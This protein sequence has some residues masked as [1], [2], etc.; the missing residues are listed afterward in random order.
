MTRLSTIA[1]TI[2]ILLAGTAAAPA[3]AQDVA[4][5]VDPIEDQ[6][7]RE[8]AG[9]RFE[10][11][12]KTYR[13]AFGTAV[14]QAAAGTARERNLA[15]AEVLLEKIDGLTERVSEQRSTEEFLSG[16]D[17]ERL[18]PVL[19]G[20]VDWRRARYR[21]AAGDLEGAAELLGGLGIVSDWWVIGPF[22][23]ERGR[24]YKTAAEPETKIDL[25]G[26][27]KGKEREVGWRKAPGATRNGYVNLDAML[28]P[29]DQAFA[30]AVAFVKS[31]S[32]QDA[33]IRLGSDEAVK[34]W[35]NGTQV[36]DRDLRRRIAFDQ[37]VVGVRARE[38]WNVL[39][40][41]VHDQTGSWGFRVRLTA[42]D[43]AALGGVSFATTREEADAA[44]AA[45]AEAKDVEGAVAGGARQFYDGLDEGARSAREMFHL[46]LLHHRRGFDAIAD[47]K[48]AKHLEDAA[49]AEPENSI[50]RYHYAQAA[51]PPVE[52]SVEKE[53]NRQRQA[54]EQVLAMDPSYAVA[55]RALAGYYTGSLTNLEKAEQLLRKALELNPDFH[56][57]RLDLA[58]VLRRRGLN[59]AAELERKKVV[60][61][62]R[63][64]GRERTARMKADELQRNGYAKE[65]AAAWEA[66]L[67]VDARSQDARRRIADLSV[68]VLARDEA[69]ALL[70]KMHSYDPYDTNSLRR[71]AELFEGAGEFD[72][73]E[74]ELRRALAVVPE[75]HGLLQALGRVQLKAGRK[76]EA[77]DTYR[78][79]LVINPKLQ[80][81]ERYVEYLDPAA[82]PYEDAYRI[83][84]EPL[85]QAAADY[86]N[87]ENDGY[88]VLLDQSVMKV[89]PDGTSSTY[90]HIAVKILTNDGVQQWRRHSVNTWGWAFKWKS[91]RVVKADG[92]EVQ[93]KTRK[94]RFQAVAQFPPLTPGDV[95]EFEYRQDQRQQSFFGDYFGTDFYFADRVPMSLSTLTLITPASREFYTHSRHIDIEPT[96][97]MSEDGQERVFVWTRKDCP[98]VRFERGMPAA[99]EIYPMVQISTF[100]DWNAFATWFSSLIRDQ[101]IASDPIKEKV[102]ELVEGKETRYEKVR[103]LYD[104]VTGEITYQAWP[105]NVHAYKPYTTT[106]IFDKREGDCKDKAILFNTMLK[107]IGV[108]AYPVL[109]MAEGSRSAEDFTLPV[110]HHFNHCISYVPDADGN[111]KALFLDGTAQYHSAGG[112]PPA[113]DRGA[114]VL[115]VKPDGGVIETIP[116]GTP[117]DMGIDQKWTVTVSED[118]KAVIEGEM[119]FRGDVATAFR[120]IFSV[121]GQRKL[122]LQS[123]L[124]QTFGKVRIQETDFDD[125]K[126]LAQPRTS[127]RMKVEVSNFAKEDGDYQT[128]PASFVEFVS[129]QFQ[130]LIARTER[131][132]DLLLSP[133]ISERTEVTYT[134]PESW[135]VEVAP[136]NATIEVDA[137]AFILDASHEGNTL[138]LKRTFEVRQPRVRTDDYPTFRDAV[139]RAASVGKQTWKLKKTAEAE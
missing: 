83:E 121:E 35:W 17:A 13:K 51:A 62:P 73:A 25:A 123:I 99:R 95:V 139:S 42:A 36:L 84:V 43:G 130:S 77:L 75:S 59:A 105:L 71:R 1:L 57:A 111:G 97:T 49:E 113:S 34:A 39:L 115:V 82:A 53:E 88:L 110:M 46:G 129:G 7:L 100:E 72:K 24:G 21:L 87:D 58:N 9:A 70:E 117:E 67:A 28:R 11:A 86:Q 20:Y 134:V 31:G 131:E 102:A 128:L 107:E 132:H 137:G 37:D 91:A 120:R 124:T 103:A 112:P 5:P 56:E 12:L 64:A 55:Y 122:V 27:Y 15:R 14:D 90:M 50:Y 89:N 133:P 8:E 114:K 127:F 78:Q 109:I 10:Q 23:N 40:L 18:G 30:Y 93:A 101:H 118:G 45:P 2:P 68:Q 26:R 38:G 44:L 32:D 63:L 125:M 104:F 48:A 138:S 79:A 16:Y 19:K 4:D 126:D 47:R 96:V 74:A 106:A 136:E 98:K 92:T 135:S 22:D 119:A 60:D 29:N 52:M 85:I 76:D 94:S 80:P 81:L 3:L 66:V 6:A 65:A 41:K 54:R 108:D 33:A 69:L 61:D 116:T